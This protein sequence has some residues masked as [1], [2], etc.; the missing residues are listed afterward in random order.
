VLQKVIVFLIVGIIGFSLVSFSYTEARV[1]EAK[2]TLDTVVANQ[3]SLIATFADVG[4]QVNT[5]NGGSSDSFD[6]LDRRTRNA[7]PKMNS[8]WPMPVEK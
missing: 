8:C 3:N 1:A 7:A 2:R 4:A 5:L 6:R